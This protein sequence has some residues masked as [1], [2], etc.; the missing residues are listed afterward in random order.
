MRNVER[1]V[2]RI[3]ELTHAPMTITIEPQHG[4]VQ[5]A[6]RLG[7]KGLEEHSE[8]IVANGIIDGLVQAVATEEKRNHTPPGRQL[9]ISKSAERVAVFSGITGADDRMSHIADIL[10]T[11]ES[12]T[13]MI[14]IIKAG[15]NAMDVPIDI[16][17]GE[18]E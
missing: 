2:R 11:A 14:D 12:I 3:M 17:N 4:E 18:D 6:Y 16:E 10:G 9:W 13:F 15:A 5:I 1:M 7:I 8:R